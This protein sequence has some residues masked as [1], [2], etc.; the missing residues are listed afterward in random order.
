MPASRTSAV[1]KSSPPPAPASQ[2]TTRQRPKAVA[3]EIAYAAPAEPVSGP[4]TAPRPRQPR[5]LNFSASAY[6]AARPY[7]LTRPADAPHILPAAP[8]DNLVRSEQDLVVR[9][10]QMPIELAAPMLAA[11]MPALDTPALLALVKAT[12]EAHHAVIAKRKRLD[13]RVVKAIIRAGHEIAILALAENRD[14]IF[15]AEDRVAMSALAEHM[16]MVRGAL[17]GRPGFVFTTAATKLNVDDG[18]GHANLRLVKLA[19]AGRHAIFVRDAAR[20]LHLTAADLAAALGATPDITLAL[21][22]CALGM[23]RAVFNHLLPLWHTHHGQPH[24]DDA[25]HHPLLM[26]IFALNAD[27]A[28]RKLSAGIAA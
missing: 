19:R 3:V 12:G 16:I 26:S 4:L 25:P 11:A 28:L 1:R 13:W 8:A 14:V 23:D 9:L 5:S 17:I 2:K 20:R 7:C 27:E 21:L 18:A 6:V 22:S 24:R 10:G 15:D